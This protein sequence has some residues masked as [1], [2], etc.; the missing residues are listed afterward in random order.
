M[1]ASA[2]MSTATWLN[3]AMLFMNMAIWLENATRLAG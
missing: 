3:L 2:T 1:S